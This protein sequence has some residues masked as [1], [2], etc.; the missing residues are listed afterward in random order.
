[1][2]P[3]PDG[4][5]DLV[6]DILKGRLRNI[7]YGFANQ[8]LKELEKE[9]EKTLRFPSNIQDNKKEKQKLATDISLK[10]FRT[11]RFLSNH[12][13]FKWEKEDYL[14]ELNFMTAK[15]QDPEKKLKSL[16]KVI[17][18]AFM[19][20]FLDELKGG[21]GKVKDQDLQDFSAKV[22]DPVQDKIKLIIRTHLINGL[23]R[24]FPEL[25]VNNFS[26]AGLELEIDTPEGL[27][28]EM[29]KNMWLI[30]S[31]KTVSY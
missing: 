3:I 14:R 12:Q 30:V 25:E 22:I 4:A 2:T 20:R 27:I 5:K 21:V 11:I 16:N 9:F 13:L 1:M 19:I 28:Q 8:D 15:S 31:G 7:L 10:L 6:V 29:Y 26:S 18:G 24:E 17:R 23:K